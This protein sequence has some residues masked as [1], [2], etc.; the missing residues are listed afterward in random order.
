M[1]ALF[2]H[3]FHESLEQGLAY[4]A[5]VD[6][7][8]GAAVAGVALWYRPSRIMN[9]PLPLL[10]RGV[11]WRRARQGWRAV[12]AIQA[13]HPH[14]VPSYYLFAVGVDPLAQ[15]TGVAGRLL[16][17][18]LARADAEG[19]PCY[20]ENSNVAK[21]TPIYEHLGFH[22][23]PMLSIGG[24]TAPPVLPMWRPVAPSAAMMGAAAH[25]QQVKPDESDGGCGSPAVGAPLP[26]QSP[27]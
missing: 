27:A 1:A 10:L 9:A 3:A 6:R 22:R 17:A 19:V 26:V 5:M 8:G 16:R 12:K 11:G 4:V 20:L 24:P 25:S 13:A 15:G 21:N 14:D 2:G 18:H 7:P 23:R